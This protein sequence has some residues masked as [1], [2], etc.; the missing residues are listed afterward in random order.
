MRDALSK[1]RDRTR[2][3]YSQLRLSDTKVHILV[4]DGKG[5]TE[6]GGDYP[7]LRPMG[8]AYL[9]SNAA[10]MQPFLDFIA[11]RKPTPFYLKKASA[12]QIMETLRKYLSSD[13]NAMTV[14]RSAEEMINMNKDD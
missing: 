7:Y 2:L 5:P 8:V 11:G 1:V 12:S 3:S 4:I 9:P 14:L 6:V 10:K 13:S